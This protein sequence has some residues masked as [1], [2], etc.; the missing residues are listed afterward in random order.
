MSGRIYFCGSH[1]TGKSTLA[2]WLAA[3]RG[4]PLIDEVASEVISRYPVG[5]DALRVNVGAITTYQH[6]VFREQLAREAAHPGG[7]VS[8]RT[9][10]DSLAY[11]AEHGEGLAD[12]LDSKAC[13]DYV[14]GLRRSTVFFVRPH[15][16]AIDAR[17]RARGDADVASQWRVDGMILYM[18]HAFRVRYTPLEARSPR[19]R[20]RLV[21][22]RLGALPGLKQAHAAGAPI[23]PGIGPKSLRVLELI[24]AD[25][26]AQVHDIAVQM[27]GPDT[28]VYACVQRLR[29][30][31]LLAGRPGAWTVVRRVT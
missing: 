4:L 29:A 19:D 28:M 24:D 27:R 8:D 9:A 7:F 26:R 5:F 25:P 15:G 11:T 14:D 6:S 3:A 16:D 31:G 20:Q 12:I 17:G 21:E 23:P 22:E 2:K 30:V 18:L 13:A 10:L 1:G